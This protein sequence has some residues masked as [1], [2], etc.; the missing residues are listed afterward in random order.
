M[1]FRENVGGHLQLL[2]S[3]FLRTCLTLSWISRTTRTLLL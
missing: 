3:L 1:R 2:H